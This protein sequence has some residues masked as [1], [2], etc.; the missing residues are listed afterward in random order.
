MLVTVDAEGNSLTILVLVPN[1]ELNVKTVVY[2]SPKYRGG[3]EIVYEGTTLDVLVVKVKGPTAVV[4]GTGVVDELLGAY[5]CT[6][7]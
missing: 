6:W 2:V 1:G 7:R 4:T 5:V 3:L